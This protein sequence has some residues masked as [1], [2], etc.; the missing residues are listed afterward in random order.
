MR[1][2]CTAGAAGGT[3]ASAIADPLQIA[4]HLQ[5]R[6]DRPKV[7]GH[8]LAQGQ[9]AHGLI[10]DLRLEPVDPGIGLDDFAGQRGVARGH[11]PDRAFDLGF[12]TAAHARDQVGQPL[13]VGVEGFYGV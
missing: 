6:H 4:R 12:G 5:R 2:I 7:G 11:R 1:G 8:R 3:W 13:Q 9:Q 10:I